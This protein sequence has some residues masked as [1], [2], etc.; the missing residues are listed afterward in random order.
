MAD[1]DKPVAAFANALSN[2]N[3]KARLLDPGGFI[4]SKVGAADLAKRFFAKAE[5]KM[6]SAGGP[7]RRPTTPAS[8]LGFGGVSGGLGQVRACDHRTVAMAC[9]NPIFN[10]R[11]GNPPSWTHHSGRV[12]DRRRSCGARGPMA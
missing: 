12:D 4:A 5:Q 3:D 11:A 8:L 10:P 2:L 7:A 6:P 9:F 1:R